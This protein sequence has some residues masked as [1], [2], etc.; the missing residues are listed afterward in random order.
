MQ[1]C[2]LNIVCPEFKMASS[3]SNIRDRFSAQEVLGMC[4]QN[5]NQVGSEVDSHLEGMSND[6]ESDLDRE[7]EQNY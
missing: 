3:T 6:E 7:L 5:P 2:V 4:V 1:I